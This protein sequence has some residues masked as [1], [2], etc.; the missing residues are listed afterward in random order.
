M[1]KKVK[2]ILCR[3]FSIFERKILSEGCMVVSFINKIVFKNVYLISTF[4]LVEN[5]KSYSFHF[6]IEVFLWFKNQN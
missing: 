1:K 4:L 2:Y 3:H 5:L 6:L